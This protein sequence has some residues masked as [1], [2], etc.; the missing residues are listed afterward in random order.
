MTNRAGVIGMPIRHSLS[1]AI[2]TAAFEAVG[3]DWTYEAFEVP[4]G[5]GA[6][7]AERVRHDLIGLSVTMPHKEAVVRAVDDLSDVARDL[8]AVNCIARR[9]GRLVGHNTDGPGLVDSLAIDESLDLTGMRGVLLGAGG[10]GRAVARAL[11]AAGVRLVV[12]NRSP[13]RAAAAVAL[14]GPGAR[15]GSLDD[16]AEADLVVNATSVGMA[17]DPSSP[18]PAGALH[19]E[20][21]I[22]DLVY[23]PSVTPLLADA[24][25]AGARTVGGLGMLVHQ[26]A[27]AFRLW[28]GIDAPVEAM[29]AGAE[30]GLAARAAG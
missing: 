18:V 1:P 21:V 28:T 30:A 24:A 3:L 15:A 11:G 19:R 9:D 6:A 22:V 14:A 10:A 27:H 17:G 29:R 25:R 12:V 26:A 8:G 23:H 2:F 13:E 4:V 16:V 7:F 20:Q 5:E